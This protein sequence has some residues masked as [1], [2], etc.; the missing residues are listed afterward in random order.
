MIRTDRLFDTAPAVLTYPETVEVPGILNTH[1][2]PRDTD[3]EG[4]GRAELFIPHLAEV[5]EDAVGIG[6]T[7]QPLTTVALAEAKAEQWRALIPE[8]SNL[9]LHVAGLITETTHPGEVVA[10]YDRPEGQEAWVAMKMFLR[11]ASNSNG[12]DVDDVS[13]MVPVL[14]AMTNSRFMHKKRPMTLMIHAERKYNQLGGRINFLGRERAAIER[15]IP[16][17]FEQVPNARIIIC[18]VSDGTTIEAIRHYRQKGLDIRGEISPHYTLYTCDDLFEGPGGGTMLNAHL[19]CLPIFKTETD[20]R[21]IEAAM[22]SGEE[23]WHYG[24]DEACH[25]DNPQKSGGVK[26]N[27]LGFVVG[28]QTQVPKA[29]VSYV[30]E[31]FVEAGTLEHLVE[32]LSHNGRDAIGLPRSPV[33]KRFRRYDWKVEE[34]IGRRSPTLGE[35]QCRVAMAGQWRKYWPG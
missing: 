1:T 13:R 30:I 16:Y 27:S 14:E 11:A 5:Y 32:F 18:H 35:L 10:G 3:A 21:T 31:K 20:R 9:K 26:I 4:D 25:I 15:D 34:T 28:G 17:L 7:K 22:V 33:T 23:C 29:T 8:R 24:T 19:F 6:N 12:A 2:H